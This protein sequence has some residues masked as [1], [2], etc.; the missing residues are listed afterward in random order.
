MFYLKSCNPIGSII[1]THQC[2]KLLRI[3]GVALYI[4]LCKLDLSFRNYRL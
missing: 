1:L 3:I 4:K 2:F